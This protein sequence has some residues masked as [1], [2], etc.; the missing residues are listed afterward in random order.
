MRQFLV[1]VADIRPMFWF[2]FHQAGEL[3]CLDFVQNVIFNLK[4]LE[5]NFKIV[6][7]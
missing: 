2:F 3:G 6:D 1:F 5:V 7:V 4:S